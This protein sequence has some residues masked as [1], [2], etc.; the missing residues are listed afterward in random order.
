MVS[1]LITCLHYSVC[2]CIRRIVT[3]KYN[4]EKIEHSHY[5]RSLFC[6]LQKAV[7]WWRSR[8]PKYF[9]LNF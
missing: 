6:S 7:S 8:Q 1:S 2:I 3:R 4:L 9:F 5:H